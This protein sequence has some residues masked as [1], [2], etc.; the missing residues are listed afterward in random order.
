MD[1]VL[2]LKSKVTQLYQNFKS[3]LGTAAEFQTA[4]EGTSSWRN[5]S[6]RMEVSVSPGLAL[7]CVMCCAFASLGIAQ[8]PV[9]CWR[10]MHLCSLPCHC[11]AH[12]WWAPMQTCQVQSARHSLVWHATSLLKPCSKT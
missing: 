5:V 10:S 1:A 4:N 6:R 3:L 7:Y 12:F 11:Q 9:G 8:E 2:G